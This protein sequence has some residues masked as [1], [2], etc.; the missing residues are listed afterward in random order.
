MFCS[1]DREKG[2]VALEEQWDYINLSDFKSE[3]CWSGFSY[4]LIYVFLLVSMAVY[5]VDTFT[6]IN[7]LAFSRWAGSIEPAIPFKISRWIFAV[8]IIVSFAL[9]IYRWLRAIRA[10]RSG[11]IAH[12]YLDSLAVRIQSIRMGQ[13]GR[14]WRRFL[15]FAELTKSRKGA[16]YVALFAYFSFESWMSTIFAD[17]PRQVVNAITL[18]SVMQM[19]LLPGGSNTESSD[20]STASQLFYNI[21]VLADNNIRQA[22][23]LVGM[24]FTL[25]IWVLSMIKLLLAVVLYLLFL[26]HHIPSEDGSLKRYC[27]RKINSRLTKIVRQKV[28]KALAKGVALQD[29][30]P[31]QPN[32]GVD[33]KPTLPTLDMNDHDKTPIV[34]TIS[35]TTTQ[36]TLP[37][38]SSRPGTA[39]PDRKPTLPDLSTFDDKPPALTRTVTQSSFSDA[40]SMSGS[41]AVS[42]YSPLDRHGT[43]PPV[44]P[45]PHQGPAPMPLS[46]TPRPR[47]NFDQT[48]STQRYG[49]PVD[50]RSHTPMS[51]STRTPAPQQQA[52]AM[53]RS[54]PPMSRQNCTPPPPAPGYRG[55]DRASPAPPMP[56]IQTPMFRSNTAPAPPSAMHDQSHMPYAMGQQDSEG[57]SPFA[58]QEPYYPHYGTPFQSHAPATVSTARS[59][60]PGTVRSPVEGVPTRTFSPQGQLNGTPYPAGDHEF[61]ARSFTPA[62]SGT[63]RSPPPAVP[64][65]WETRTM[66]PAGAATANIYTAFSPVHRSAP[67]P[68]TETIASGQDG[69]DGGYV[70]DDIAPISV[71]PGD[72]HEV[73]HALEGGYVAFNPSANTASPSEEHPSHEE[74]EHYADEHHD[75]HAIDTERASQAASPESHGAD[76]FIA[77]NPSSTDLYKDLGNQHQ[78]TEGPQDH[79]QD[80][81]GHEHLYDFYAEQHPEPPA[82]ALRAVSPSA[83]SHEGYTAFNPFEDSYAAGFVHEHEH[84]PEHEPEHE[85]KPEPQHDYQHPS[86]QAE[87]EMSETSVPNGGGYVAFSPV[88]HAV[89]SPVETFTPATHALSS[90][91]TQFAPTTHAMS[92]PTGQ[93]ASTTAYAI[94]SPTAAHAPRIQTSADAHAYSTSYPTDQQSHPAERAYSPAAVQPYRPDQQHH[95]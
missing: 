87:H 35:R 15:V 11:S 43:A 89:S 20:G 75:L 80:G 46:Q 88:T 22:I 93:F 12:S 50:P 53:A 55:M 47:Q 90:P 36:T 33:R 86:S 39:A 31:T 84:E 49:G 38:Y 77:F 27:K 64:A 13:N 16:E 70:H 63:P 6:A 56:R 79:A 95:F 3:S 19:D 32:V 48:P 29:R 65:G 92:S 8:C 40:A 41:T 94:S 54:Q 18:Y 74:R 45:L 51:R 91:T 57:Y 28:N 73:P 69:S 81:L 67:M 21:K 30:K 60:T 4:F 68:L 61:S 52:Q 66:S 9:L 83:T 71:T 58:D 34:T 59:L 76:G 23:V 85:H 78:H 24:I 2:P 5:G 7:L 1:G 14:G 37:A 10:M 42:T 82:A 25:I 72:V 26:W 62:G 17:G 44:P